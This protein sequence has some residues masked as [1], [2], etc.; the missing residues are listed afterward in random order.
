MYVLN[1]KSSSCLAF[2]T[3]NLNYVVCRCRTYG[4]G[5]RGKLTQPL[6]W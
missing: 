4:I 6:I 5:G 1:L 2:E 3:K